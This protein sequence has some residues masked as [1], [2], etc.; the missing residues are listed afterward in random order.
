MCV[1]IKYITLKDGREP[2]LFYIRD[3]LNTVGEG[4][5]VKFPSN[6]VGVPVE[7]IKNVKHVYPKWKRRGKFMLKVDSEGVVT[8]KTKSR[9]GISQ[10]FSRWN[11]THVTYQA[12]KVVTNECIGKIPLWEVATPLW[13]VEVTSTPVEKN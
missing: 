12:D 5:F 8:I 11:A 2:C 13:N 10:F 9:W 3:V 1:S 6:I 7:Y 4:D